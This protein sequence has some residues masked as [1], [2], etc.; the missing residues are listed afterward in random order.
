[1]KKD[2]IGLMPQDVVLDQF[3]SKFD[4][5]T[6]LNFTFVSLRWHNLFTSNACWYK[7]FLCD[8]KISPELLEETLQLQNQTLSDKFY[9]QLYKR[10]TKIL[11]Y[12]KKYSSEFY[13]ISDS[14]E[15]KNLL[16]ICSP[17][18]DKAL[19][20]FS[21]QNNVGLLILALAVGNIEFVRGYLIQ[22]DH[23]TRY[24]FMNYLAGEGNNLE[25]LC[26]L[27]KSLHNFNLNPGISTL[28]TALLFQNHEIIVYL[29]TNH[30]IEPT[31]DTI[32]WAKENGHLSVLSY[33]YTHRPSSNTNL[34][35]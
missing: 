18:L 30:N 25:M 16:H 23:R 27:L 29:N 21:N 28:H 10:Y 1:M 35:F 24:D 12:V 31:Q 9:L 5:K 19:A 4:N 7:K 13:D 8:F 2:I 34:N 6:L 26:Y 3:L 14:F 32:D 22:T 15:L 20:F 33:L 11:A 17:Q